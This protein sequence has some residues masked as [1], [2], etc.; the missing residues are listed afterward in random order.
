VVEHDELPI[1]LIIAPVGLDAIEGPSSREKLAPI[2]SLF[3]V[4]GEK[5]GLASCRKIL[6]N[7]G[8]GH[9][10]IIHTRNPK[11]IERFGS[12]ISASRILVNAGG[13][14]G[15]IG[16]DNGLMPS[17]TLGCG[18]F[19]GISTTDNVSYTHLLNI[20]RVVHPLRTLAAAPDLL[21]AAIASPDREADADG[22]GQVLGGGHARA[23]GEGTMAQ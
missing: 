23:R 18:T 17:L 8:L 6:A 14:Q 7:E 19:G 2:L 5:E 20:K 15:C 3:T 13:S 4:D 9:N 1:R 12:E 16:V 21:A 10:A 11:L 22:V